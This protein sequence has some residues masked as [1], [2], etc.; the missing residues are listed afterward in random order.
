MNSFSFARSNTPDNS[1]PMLFILAAA[2]RPPAVC[3]AAPFERD[4]GPTRL[5][6]GGAQGLHVIT[7]GADELEPPSSL[8]TPNNVTN[9]FTFVSLLVFKASMFRIVFRS[10]SL[11]NEVSNISALEFTLRTASRALLICSAE[12]MSILFS[13]IRSA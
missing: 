1:R 13:R 3:P 8:L 7:T 9:L 12:H 2:W 4:D 10:T 6:D 5:E 11:P